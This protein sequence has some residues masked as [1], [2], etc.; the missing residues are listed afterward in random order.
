VKE[1]GGAARFEPL[2]AL[3]YRD[4]RRKTENEGFDAADFAE[5]KKRYL[6]ATKK[7]SGMQPAKVGR[8]ST[9]NPLNPLSRLLLS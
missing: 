8:S 6:K 4:I 5:L 9:R 2:E 1:E 7:A 3:P